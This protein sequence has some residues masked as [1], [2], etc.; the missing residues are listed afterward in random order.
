MLESL[1]DLGPITMETISAASWSLKRKGLIDLKHPKARV[2]KDGLEPIE[3]YFHVLRHPAFGTFIIDTGIEQALRDDPQRAVIRGLIGRVARLDRMNIHVTLADRLGTDPL[4][5]VLLTHLHFDHVS[6]LPDV[7]KGTPIFAGAGE[8]SARS[9]RNVA[10]RGIIDRAFSGHDPINE[11]TFAED[12]DERFA[13]VIDV[14]GDAT[15]WAIHA[16]GHTPGSTA[17]LVRTTQGPVLL[18]GDTCHTAWGWENEVTP[19]TFTVDRERN[20][21]SLA[22]LRRLARENPQLEVR[23]GH[24]PLKSVSNA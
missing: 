10:T 1:G 21:Q 15:L 22:R 7:P 12:P 17:Y 4:A 19:G 8:A 14:F 6:G 18:T 20:A 3:I 11:W 9:F 5:G 24:Q 16:P 23:L 2:L 13:G